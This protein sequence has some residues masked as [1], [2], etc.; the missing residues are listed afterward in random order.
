MAR[1]VL[2]SI[3]RS[4]WRPSPAQERWVGIVLGANLWL[5]VLVSWRRWRVESPAELGMLA[6][7]AVVGW[8][9]L[10]REP[11]Q[12]HATWMEMASCA[13]AIL[14]GGL[15]L[16][17]APSPGA[18]PPWIQGVF[19]VGTALAVW[20]LLRLGRSFAVLP[21]RRSLVTGGPYRLLRHPAYLGELL[22]LTAC[23]LAAPTV[24]GAV[25]MCLAPVFLGW[26]IHLEESLLAQDA[27]YQ[28]YCQVVKWRLL[29]GLW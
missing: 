4:R 13:P 6:L 26:R 28:R 9:L 3:W 15:A 27:G 5:L 22:M 7:T 23:F 2:G 10:R 18:W 20:S 11:A 14:I 1:G 16:R 24:I 8:L 17:W 12:R 21:G 29:P 25:L 19:S